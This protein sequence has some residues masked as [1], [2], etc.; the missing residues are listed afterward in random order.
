MRNATERYAGKRK[1]WKNVT[2]L[3]TVYQDS[4]AS[5]MQFD[6]LVYKAHLVFDFFLFYPSE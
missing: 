2:M 3:L 4:M 6:V 5:I 1:E